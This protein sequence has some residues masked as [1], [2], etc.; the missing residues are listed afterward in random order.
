MEP[1]LTCDGDKLSLFPLKRPHLYKLFTESVEMFWS[2]GEVDAGTDKADYEGMSEGQQRF[3]RHVLGFFAVGDSL[4]IQNC[5]EQF[6]GEVQDNSA[7]LFFAFQAGM[8]AIHSVVYNELIETII[9]D[10]EQKEETDTPKNTW[11]LKPPRVVSLSLLKLGN[12]YRAQ[13]CSHEERTPTSRW[14]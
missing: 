7:R 5:L 10:Q 13:C 1:L 6:C 12:L 11:G 4:V 14:P 2:P 9:A 3:V 8:E